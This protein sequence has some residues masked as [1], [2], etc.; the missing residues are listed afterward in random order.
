MEQKTYIHKKI[1]LCRKCSGTGIITTYE[2]R[3]VRLLNPHRQ[4]CPQ[5]RGTGRVVVSGEKILNV[6]PYEPVLLS[7]D[8]I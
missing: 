3:D 4:Q 6:E 1:C 7:V 8:S 2:P 5:C